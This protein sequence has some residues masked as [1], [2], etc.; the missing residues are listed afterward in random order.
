[1]KCP[2]TVRPLESIIMFVYL[3]RRAKKVL[4]CVGVLQVL[5]IH[6]KNILIYIHTS[7]PKLITVIRVDVIS[8]FH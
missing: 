8:Y 2:Q 5:E 3:W 4:G 1:M 6:L 7:T